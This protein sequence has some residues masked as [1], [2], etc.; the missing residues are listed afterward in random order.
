MEHC[1]RGSGILPEPEP[2][3][4]PAELRQARPPVSCRSQAISYLLCLEYFTI[5]ILQRTSTSLLSIEGDDTS[6][7]I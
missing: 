7:R 5:H 1:R 2:S 6:E 4:G 3:R